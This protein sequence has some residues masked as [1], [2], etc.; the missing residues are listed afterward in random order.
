MVQHPTKRGA[1]RAASSRPADCDCRAGVSRR[2]FTAALVAL[3]GAAMVPQVAFGGDEPTLI[4]T[5]HHFYP[6]EYQK[7][8]LDWEESRKLPHFA[9]QVGWMRE[10]S[11][12]E[13]DKAGIR[14]A[15]LSLP[16]TPGLWFDA[17][18]GAAV[19][20]V[21]ICNDYGA[22]MV[23]D[24]PGRFALFAPLSMLD[25]DTT[26]KEIEY[27][28]DTLHADGIGLQSNY[29][30]R[31][32]G[33]AMYQPVLEELNRRKAL[34]YVH[35]LVAN[36]CRNLS[37]GTFPAVIEVPHDTTRTVTS[38]LLSG[39]F[40]RLRDIRWLFSHAGGTIPMMAGRID[41]FYGAR[42]NLKEFAP[43]GIEGELRRLHYD[44][45]NA[46][47]PAQMAALLKLVPVSQIT[48]GTDYPY[49]PT[50]QITNLRELG[51]GAD[52]LQAIGSDNAL[53]LVPRLKA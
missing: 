8:W 50:T 47:H 14:T 45:A 33:N 5:H 51:L 40:A 34:V 13:M 18:P 16:S 29:G 12:E 37:V 30:D 31:W 6:P 23:R 26:L 2:Q 24:F 35:P 22:S 20:M 17:D 28:F 38:L 52:Q 49:F 15:I 21:R 42:P 1:A 48:Y 39:T 46:T 27:A 4:D 53:R 32:L 11:L 41:A 44:T 43:E 9:T 3:G 10:K 25:I 36:C 19:R 7:A